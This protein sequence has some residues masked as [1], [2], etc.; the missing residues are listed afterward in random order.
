MSVEGD[1]T[2]RELNVVTKERYCNDSNCFPSS[3]IPTVM[4]KPEQLVLLYRPQGSIKVTR[5]RGPFASGLRDVCLGEWREEVP[6][7]HATYCLPLEVSRTST[8]TD[9]DNYHR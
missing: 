2:A 7:R 5:R 9:A 4:V 8:N 6:V 3:S 1:I